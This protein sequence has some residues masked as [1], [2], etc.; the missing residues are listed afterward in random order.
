MGMAGY[1]SGSPVG[2]LWQSVTSFQVV[3]GRAAAYRRAID[4]LLPERTT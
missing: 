3:N 1:I 4:E 2:R